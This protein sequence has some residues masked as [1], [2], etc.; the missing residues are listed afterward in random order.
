MAQAQEGREN[1]RDDED[2]EQDDEGRC[3]GRRRHADVT[4]G[5]ERV[6]GVVLKE[7]QLPVLRAS[8]A[9]WPGTH[10]PLCH[11]LLL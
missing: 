1:A 5:K 3:E 8:S 9:G 2:G 10:P 6:K 7:T 11:F 4:L